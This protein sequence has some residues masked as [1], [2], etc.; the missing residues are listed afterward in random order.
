MVPVLRIGYSNKFYEGEE[1]GKNGYVGQKKKLC[2]PLM[3][4]GSSWESSSKV[5]MRKN[6]MF[7]NV[8]R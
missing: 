5:I 6:L 2:N 8:W 4:A 3:A 1:Y 7:V